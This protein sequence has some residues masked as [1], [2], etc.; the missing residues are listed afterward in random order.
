MMPAVARTPPR[1]FI[2]HR[3][4]VL[5]KPSYCTICSGARLLSQKN[6]LLAG[7]RIAHFNQPFSGTFLEG[8]VGGFWLAAA[9]TRSFL[10]Q[11]INVGWV[12]SFLA[13]G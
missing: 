5:S 9:Y 12:E 1:G 13:Q 8:N 7:K 4:F 10:Q 3:F 6:N 11:R 2:C